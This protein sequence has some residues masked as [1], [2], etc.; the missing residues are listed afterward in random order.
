M[1]YKNPVNMTSRAWHGKWK[2]ENGMVWN[3]PEEEENFGKW[4][5]FSKSAKIF[6]G[7][8]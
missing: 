8:M 1:A 3:S 6:Y 2:M 5:H 4:F 7:M